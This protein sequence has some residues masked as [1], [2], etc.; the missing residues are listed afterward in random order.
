MGLTPYE[1][2]L[3]LLKMSKDML[4]QK[5]HTERDLAVRKWEHAISTN[6]GGQEF[7]TEIPEFP[8]EDEIVGK[9]KLLNEFISEK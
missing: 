8:T 5:Y 1:I 2:R 9:A 4:E 7:L 6:N 3:E